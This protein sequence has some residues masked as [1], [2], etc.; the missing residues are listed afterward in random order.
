M[1]CR[2]AHAPLSAYGLRG[3][4][5]GDRHWIAWTTMTRASP[6]YVVFCRCLVVRTQNNPRR[7]W[8]PLSLVD[9][10]RFRD[11]VTAYAGRVHP[12]ARVLYE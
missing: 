4:L 11:V 10:M 2:F 6:H 5:S 1:T 8:I 12:V 7:Y 9:I 3:G